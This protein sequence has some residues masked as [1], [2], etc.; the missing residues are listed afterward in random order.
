MWQDLYPEKYMEWINNTKGL[1]DGSTQPLAPFHINEI[2]KSY[3]SVSYS[4]QQKDLGYTYPELQQ[5]LDT[6]KTD[7]VFDKEKY[8]R[9]LRKTI[10][11]KYSTTGKSALQL[12]KH[13]RVATAHMSAMTLGNLAVENFP[14][15]LAEEVLKNG[16]DRQQPLAS[17]PEASWEENDYIVDVVYDR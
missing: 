5:W 15:A 7:G 10:E 8:Q 1:Q 2:G 9:L 11:L 17:P 16:A 14:S 13:N 6:Y 3:D 4:F 12:P